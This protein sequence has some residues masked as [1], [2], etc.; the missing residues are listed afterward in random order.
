[1]HRAFD[2]RFATDDRVE[3]LLTGEYSVSEVAGLAGFNDI[4]YF[5]REFKR[6]TGVSPSEY[7]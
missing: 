3:L 5:S 7:E 1:L 2:F 4:S 6:A